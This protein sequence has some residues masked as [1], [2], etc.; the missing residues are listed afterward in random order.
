MA[1]EL[2]HDALY[3]PFQL[4]PFYENEMPEILEVEM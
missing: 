4:K 1:A 3:G 2:E